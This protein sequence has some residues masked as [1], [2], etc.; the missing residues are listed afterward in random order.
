LFLFDSVHLQYLGHPIAN[1]PMYANPHIFHS[2]E[3]ATE[4]T[5]EEL[6]ARLENIGK[7]VAATTLADQLMTS[8]DDHNITPSHGHNNLKFK[9]MWS[10][11]VCDVCGTQ[12]YIDPSP[13]ELEIWLHAWKY[14]IKFTA[15]KDGE[16]A[17][18]WTFE[19]EIP[20]W[21][22]EDWKGPRP[23]RKSRASSPAPAIA[24]QENS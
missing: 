22:R 8:V 15:E 18:E 14:C 20:E 5:D 3:D 17:K 12:L 21:A 4:A 11:E 2:R 10:G 9:E 19:S 13:E 6:V 23:F 7:T 1:D 16:E 24:V